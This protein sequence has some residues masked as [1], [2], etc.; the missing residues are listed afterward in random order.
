MTNARGAETWIALSSPVAPDVAATA[1]LRELAEE[2][3][4]PIVYVDDL[5]VRRNLPAAVEIVRQM[6]Q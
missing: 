4:Q 5:L 2:Q 6:L 1:E 3:V